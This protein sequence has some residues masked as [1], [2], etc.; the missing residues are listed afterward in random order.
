MPDWEIGEKFPLIW[1][2]WERGWAIADRESG[3]SWAMVGLARPIVGLIPPV[4][5][6][7]MG[8]NLCWEK[9]VVMEVCWEWERTPAGGDE[10][11][12]WESGDRLPPLAECGD[13]CICDVIWDCDDVI[14]DCDDVMLKEV[15]V[16]MGVV[17]GVVR[18]T[19][20]STRPADSYCLLLCSICE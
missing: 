18:N 17:G 10:W 6:V 11:L 15:A 2:G 20:G 3:D 8:A 5:L 1:E 4:T 7:I 12:L 14:C 16:L 19:D 9:V 13:I